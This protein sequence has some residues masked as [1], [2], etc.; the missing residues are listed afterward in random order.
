LPKPLGRGQHRLRADLVSPN[1]NLLS[2][3]AEATVTVAP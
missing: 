1:G 2:S 3:S